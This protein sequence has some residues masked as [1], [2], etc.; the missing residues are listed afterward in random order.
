MIETPRVPM[1]WMMPPLPLVVPV[2]VTVSP[3]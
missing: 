3:P 1:F 2:P